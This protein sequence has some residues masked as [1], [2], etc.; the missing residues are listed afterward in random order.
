MKCSNYEFALNIKRKYNRLSRDHN[1]LSELTGFLKPELCRLPCKIIFRN[2][3][4][5]MTQLKSTSVAVKVEQ[6]HFNNLR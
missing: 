5:W 1:H 4:I 3:K 6:L 2:D